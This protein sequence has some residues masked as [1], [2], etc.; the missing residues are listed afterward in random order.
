M[1]EIALI[2][3]LWSYKIESL[4]AR[5]RAT[6]LY[7]LPC[8][9]NEENWA[10]EVSCWSYTLQR[11][12]ISQRTKTLL[13]LKY[14]GD[15]GEVSVPWEEV[16]QRGCGVSILGVTQKPNGEDPE[17][18]ALETPALGRRLDTTRDPS[19]PKHS[20]IR[21]QTHTQTSVIS[22]IL[23]ALY[24]YCTLTATSL[25]EEKLGSNSIWRHNAD[26][27]IFFFPQKEKGKIVKKVEEFKKCFFL[28][29]RNSLAHCL[30]AWSRSFF[31]SYRADDNKTM[32]NLLL[33]LILNSCVYE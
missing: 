20:V 17:Q 25:L 3:V 21:N 11:L 33:Y 9:Q 4:E 19:S 30:S 14:D 22:Q 23:C 27:F 15:G 32:R 13:S 18:P 31:Q 24:L 28:S 7:C 6:V 26:L 12:Q 16:A 29:V 2:S 5:S 1:P 8:H 10:P